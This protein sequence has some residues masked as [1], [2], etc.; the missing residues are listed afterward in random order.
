VAAPPEC[1][2]PE[3][4]AEVETDPVMGGVVLLIVL[5]ILLS[6]IK[7]NKLER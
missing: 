1:S 5:A 2:L 4:H 7:I 3:R 6:I